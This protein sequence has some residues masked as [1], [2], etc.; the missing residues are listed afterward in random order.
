MLERSP[1]A[2]VRDWTANE[3]SLRKLA[4]MLLRRDED[5]DEAVSEIKLQAWKA[6]PTLYQ[7]EAFGAWVAT[8]ASRVLP[9]QS[10]RVRKLRKREVSLRDIEN[11][12]GAL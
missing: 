4:G 10:R 11:L 2:F 12:D 9:K 7:R 5:R 1:E 3:P 6:Y 8:I